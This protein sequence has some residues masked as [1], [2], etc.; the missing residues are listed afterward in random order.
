MV[1]WFASN[2]EHKKKELEA[3]LAG[4]PLHLPRDRGLYFNPE[5]TG[6][7]FVENALIKARALYDL[8]HEPVIADDS[9]LCVDAL[10]GRP[11]IHSARY[12]EKEGKQLDSHERNRL[13]LAEMTGIKDRRAR[14]IC[15]MVLYLGHDRFYIVQETLEGELTT[16]ER[17]SGG[18]GYDPIFYLPYYEK[19]VAELSEEEK[20]RISHRGKAGSILRQMLEYTR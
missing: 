14:F 8:V 18:F 12:G 20:N 19:T 3:I 15:A 5:E 4:L 11:G 16:E 2:N 13:L 10:G 6:M 1:L 7:S 17:G 9:G